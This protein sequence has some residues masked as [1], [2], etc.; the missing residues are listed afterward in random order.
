MSFVFLF[1]FKVLIKVSAR[2]R[3]KHVTLISGLEHCLPPGQ[4]LKTV[5]KTMAT[6]FACSASVGL[7]FLCP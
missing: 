5:A 6:R 2:G 7:F 3:T 1:L 4:T